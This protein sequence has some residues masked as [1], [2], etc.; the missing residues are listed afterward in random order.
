[1][2]DPTGFLKYSREVPARRPVEVRISDW[3][4]VY[5]DFDRGALE[6]TMNATLARAFLYLDARG[7][8]GRDVAKDP[9][10]KT[11]GYDLLHALLRLGEQPGRPRPGPRDLRAQV[12]QPAGT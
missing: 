9:A 12:V 1:M 10:K 8:L 5:Q 6:E 2:A 7:L 4:E 11:P 3:R